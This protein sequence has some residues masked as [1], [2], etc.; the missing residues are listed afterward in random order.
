[1][2]VPPPIGASKGANLGAARRNKNDEFYTPR[3][4]VDQELRHYVAHFKDKTVLCNCDDPSW[5]AFWQVFVEQFEFYGLTK[6]ISTHYANGKPS[7]SL[8]YSGRDKPLIEMPLSGDGDFRSPECIALL[9]QADI[10]VT[11]PPFSLFREYVAQLMEHGKKFLIIGNSNAITYKETFR[12]VKGGQLWLGVTAPKEF[13]QPD[14]SFKSFGNICWF[15]NLSHFKR[16]EK[17]EPFRS[18]EEE[19]DLYPRY[20]NYDAIEVGKV[21]DIPKGYAGAMGVPITFLGRHN[22]MQFEILGLAAGNIKGMA[23]L[24]SK[25]GKDGPYIGGK[26]KY[27]RILIRYVTPAQEKQS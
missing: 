26:L 15:T 6:L 21:Q 18:F 27:G 4:A 2:S 16:A 14:G 11:N 1:M 25:T 22:P 20:D 10:V 3:E 8:E 19:P 17:L 24:P 7:Y 13:K 23:G 5:S 12:L 9:K